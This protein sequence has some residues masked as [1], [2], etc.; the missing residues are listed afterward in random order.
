MRGRKQQAKDG[1]NVGSIQ[2]LLKEIQK[3]GLKNLDDIQRFINEEMEQGLVPLYTNA[4]RSVMMAK[5]KERK[6]YFKTDTFAKELRLYLL[7]A[8]KDLIT[9][10]NDTL[11]FEMLR[12]RAVDEKDFA[13]KEK[14]LYNG[15][16]IR[17]ITFTSDNFTFGDQ[18]GK[19]GLIQDY[20]KFFSA[21]CS[22]EVQNSEEAQEVINTKPNR[23]EFE[24]EG[25]NYIYYGN[26]QIC[27]I[28]GADMTDQEVKESLANMKY[29]VAKDNGFKDGIRSIGPSSQVKYIYKE[30]TPENFCPSFLLLP[31]SVTGTFLIE[32]TL[33][34]NDVFDYFNLIDEKRPLPS[35]MCYWD[36]LQSCMDFLCALT[37]TATYMNEEQRQVIK[38]W[39]DDYYKYK[40]QV[41]K[42]K[43]VY[44]KVEQCLHEFLNAFLNNSELSRFNNLVDKVD[45]CKKELIDIKKQSFYGTVMGLLGKIPFCQMIHNQ[46][47]TDFV[48]ILESISKGVDGLVK[49]GKPET[50]VGLIRS[51]AVQVFGLLPLESME[52]ACFPF[53]A[54]KG[55]LLGGLI[56]F[57][58]DNDGLFEKADKLNKAYT[59]KK[60]LVKKK[61]DDTVDLVDKANQEI[62]TYIE[63]YIERKPTKSVVKPSEKQA[64]TDI[65]YHY[66]VNLP[67][68]P[69]RRRIIASAMIANSRGKKGK[70]PKDV[71][72]EEFINEFRKVMDN[73]K[74]KEVVV[75][76]K[77]YN[78]A[79]AVQPFGFPINKMKMEEKMDIES[80]DEDKKEEDEKE[81]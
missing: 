16:I 61:I 39:V 35:N 43:N 12:K 69:L 52:N 58:S 70:I 54:P 51:A 55:S 41:I 29:F 7:Y 45:G 23:G 80:E 14:E 48:P 38:G 57:N 22:P 5:S 60:K 67:P 79:M 36:T 76:E 78:S 77:F 26:Q 44:M 21:I 62:R 9:L 50:V 56:D 19:T 66:V 75:S 74:K 20:D 72:F 63:G 6:I 59:K 34:Y 11:F 4:V 30:S 18:Q 40:S 42:V 24:V 15:G 13:P 8:N 3:R 64:I 33:D 65:I 47:K 17:S 27:I 71:A 73:K 46:F 28:A 25:T 31:Q 37:I 32:V 1:I 10:T 68:S 81:E 49:G 2:Y 53:I